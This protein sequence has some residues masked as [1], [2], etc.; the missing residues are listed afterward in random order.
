MALI[1]VNRNPTKRQLLVFA[2]VLFPCFCALVGY[3]ALLWPGSWPLSIS[4]W[5]LGGLVAGSA[6]VAPRFACLVY[7]AWM[8]AAL[9]LRCIVSYLLM[10]I[11]FFFLMVPI[12]L[13]MRM[14][15]R[16][17][18]MRKFDSEAGTYWTPQDMRERREQ[19]FR[20]F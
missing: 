10:F 5:V 7:L 11:V 15:G 19:Y 2:D 8:Y 1:G 12:G 18:L 16:D 6:L 3:L 4:I 14:L 20:Q 17:P 13:V 9:P